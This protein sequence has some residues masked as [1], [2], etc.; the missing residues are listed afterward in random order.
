[1]TPATIIR[2]AQ[3][4][5]VRLTLSSTGIIKA[6]GDGAAVSRW[7]DVIREHKAEIIE[8][9]KVGAGHVDILERHPGAVAAELPKHGDFRDDRRTC[10]ECAN[11]VAR[12]CQAAK[13]G[14]L[15]A[16]RDYEPIRDLPRRCE[17]YAPGAEDPDQRPGRERWLG[18]TAKTADTEMQC[19]QMI[20]A[21]SEGRNGRNG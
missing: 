7:L 9:L 12:R 2:E 18:L 15:V 11:L 8:A 3:S 5:G 13:R 16:A 1:M 19:S 14:E 17:G 20:S 6:T 21:K 4:D 10:G